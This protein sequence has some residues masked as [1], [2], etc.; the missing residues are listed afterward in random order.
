MVLY[1]YG[2]PAIAPQGENV[3]ITEEFMTL[4]KKKFERVVLFYDNDEAGIKAAK[5]IVNKHKVEN[6]ILP[7]TDA[8]DISDYVKDFG[9]HNGKLI[10]EILLKQSEESF[11]KN[12]SGFLEFAEELNTNLNGK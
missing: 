6:I 9:F 1:Q 4:L 11:M 5:K 3:P 8:K 2:Y 7:V 12:N 10:M